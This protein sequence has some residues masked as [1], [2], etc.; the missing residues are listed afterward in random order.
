M[1]EVCQNPITL[2]KKRN[3]S[4]SNTSHVSNGVTETVFQYTYKI[5]CLMNPINKTEIF[6]NNLKKLEVEHLVKDLKVK[7]F[8]KSGSVCCRS[9]GIASVG[10]ESVGI[11][12]VG[13]G[14]I[15]SGLIG[16]GSVCSGDLTSYFPGTI[17]IY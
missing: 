13:S 11:G 6:C 12:S 4:I 3:F 9:V 2:H 10:I 14:S 5:E 8:V 15:G 16:R 7:G 17:L 1:F